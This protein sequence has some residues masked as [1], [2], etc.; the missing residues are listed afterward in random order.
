MIS[1][2][3]FYFPKKKKKINRNMKRSLET[4]DDFMITRSGKKYKKEITDV[5]PEND[6]SETH[7]VEPTVKITV[8]EVPLSQMKETIHEMLPDHFTSDMEEI[9]ILDWFLDE[10]NHTSSDSTVSLTFPE[11]QSQVDNLVNKRFGIPR[12]DLPDFPFYDNYSYG[13]NPSEMVDEMFR[14]LLW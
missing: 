14:G 4:N 10:L 5:A 6:T 13:L 3:F 11:W 9:P 8:K 1:Y 7:N 12:L 2:L